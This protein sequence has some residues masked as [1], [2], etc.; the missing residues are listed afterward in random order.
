MKRE[1]THEQ[2]HCGCKSKGRRGKNHDAGEPCRLRSRAE[3]ARPFRRYDPQANASSGLG[4]A[5]SPG[6][7]TLDRVLGGANVGDCIVS[8]P[9]ANLDLLPSDIRLAGAEVELVSAN[10]REYVLR[11]ALASL[12]ARL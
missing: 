11:E 9:V 1:G 5:G 7:T 3:P 12:R 6:K 8:T 4:V 10:E 2:N